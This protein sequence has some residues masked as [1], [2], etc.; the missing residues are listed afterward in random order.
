VKEVERASGA[1][2]A[3]PGRAAAETPVAHTVCELGEK[4]LYVKGRRR[5]M[6]AESI[7]FGYA[8]AREI[9]SRRR[10]F[11]AWTGFALAYA[12]GMLALMSPHVCTGAFVSMVAAEVAWISFMLWF[13]YIHLD[14]VRREDGTPWRTF[15]LPNGMTL[16]RLVM[17]PLVGFAAAHSAALRTNGDWILWP[18]VAVVVSDILD[19]QIARFFKLKSDWG[20]M[21]DPA[22]D[23]YLACWFASGLWAAGLLPWWLAGVIIFRYAGTLAGIFTVWGLGLSIRVRP[24]WPG[25]AA[26]LAVDVYLPF[27]LAGALRFPSWLGSVWHVWLFRVVAAVVGLN[28][29]YYFW[30]LFV[31]LARRKH[32][33]N[34]EPP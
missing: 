11:L 8:R 7:R 12:G 28:I 27:L 9:P 4:G 21:A 10:S 24:T 25:R 1:G 13:S 30:R 34:A 15:L 29:V 19:G 6:L 14:M 18:L 3:E 22:S 32:D 2:K 33:P 17:V 23:V 20:R 31:W 5:R 26:N 16:T